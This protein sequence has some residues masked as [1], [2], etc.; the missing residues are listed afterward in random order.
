VGWPSSL[1][2]GLPSFVGVNVVRRCQCR[3]SSAPTRWRGPGSLRARHID[4]SSLRQGWQR[5]REAGE[6]SGPRVVRLVRCSG[7]STASVRSGESDRR[8]GRSGAVRPGHGSAG[9]PAAAGSRP[10]WVTGDGGVSA[11]A[12]GC[13]YW[14][15]LNGVAFPAGR[16][17]CR[18]VRSNGSKPSS[19]IDPAGARHGPLVRPTRAG[20][21]C[22][23]SAADRRPPGPRPP[24]GSVQTLTANSAEGPSTRVGAV[25]SPHGPVELAISAVHERPSGRWRPS[26]G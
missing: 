16:P 23:V 25:I 13:T 12:L 22:Q 18:T 6:W 9:P 10:R 15:I 17:W 3:S 14:P 8:V 20:L 5:S 19:T 24:A 11:A 2:D 4:A 7:R 26:V 1:R 21:M